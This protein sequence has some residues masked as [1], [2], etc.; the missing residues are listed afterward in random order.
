MSFIGKVL[1]ERIHRNPHFFVDHITLLCGQVYTTHIRRA[2]TN[3][4]SLCNKDF[5]LMKM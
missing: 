4:N 5:S 2:G 1:H 3:A